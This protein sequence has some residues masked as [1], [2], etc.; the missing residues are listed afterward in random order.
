MFFMCFC[1]KTLDGYFLQDDFRGNIYIILNVVYFQFG[2]VLLASLSS[3]QIR[4]ANIKNFECTVY[5]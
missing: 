4:K 2:N 5:I 3:I 1:G